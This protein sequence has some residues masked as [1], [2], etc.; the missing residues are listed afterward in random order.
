MMF[1]SGVYP[2]IN[3]LRKTFQDV[4][5][6]SARVFPVKFGDLPRGRSGNVLGPPRWVE[7]PQKMVKGTSLPKECPCF[8][9]DESCIAHLSHILLVHCIDIEVHFQRM[10]VVG[11]WEHWFCL[12]FWRCASATFFQWSFMGKFQLE[13]EIVAI[14]SLVPLQVFCRCAIIY[15]NHILFQADNLRLFHQKD[16]ETNLSA[17]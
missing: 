11:R 13:T 2:A 1:P 12:R 17:N 14:Q 8:Q 10:V 7:P 16:N 9:G 5:G 6:L 3:S 4:G 15:E